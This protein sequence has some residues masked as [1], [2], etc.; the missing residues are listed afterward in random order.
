MAGDVKTGCIELTFI[1]GSSSTR[2]NKAKEF[3][4]FMERESPTNIYE[5]SDNGCMIN[6]PLG[7]KPQAQK[8]VIETCHRRRDEASLWYET[9]VL[10]HRLGLDKTALATN[11][12]L[13]ASET[14]DEI[15]DPI[16]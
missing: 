14:E 8:T 2:R 12:I 9:L 5:P 3:W 6:S 11:R 4:A 13:R 15:K 1:Q 7:D 10:F 16:L